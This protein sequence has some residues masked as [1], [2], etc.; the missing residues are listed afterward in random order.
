MVLSTP[1]NTAVYFRNIWNESWRIT[2][3]KTGTKHVFV[4]ASP[5]SNALIRVGN[6]KSNDA[7]NLSH[8][9]VIINN[10]IETLTIPETLRFKKKKNFCIFER[11]S[12]QLSV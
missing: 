4:S 3:S 12:Y 5:P 2:T 8:E 6:T 1:L 10:Q 7:L 11:I 9:F